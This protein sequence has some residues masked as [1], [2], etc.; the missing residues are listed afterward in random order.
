[1]AID[2]CWLKRADENKKEDK[3]RMKQSAAFFIKLVLIQSD[4][5][6]SNQK[7]FIKAYLR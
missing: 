3:K 5:D 2:F 4:E 7:L 1:L 6:R